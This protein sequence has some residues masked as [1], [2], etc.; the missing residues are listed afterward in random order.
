MLL[1][2]GYWIDPINEFVC[3]TKICNSKYTLG[4]F[5]VDQHVYPDW[6]S[7]ALHVQYK[8]RSAFEDNQQLMSIMAMAGKESLIGRSVPWYVRWFGSFALH[9]PRWQ[10]W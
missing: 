4:E 3:A 8:N 9:G 10:M 6:A 7:D 5:S 1:M 2:T